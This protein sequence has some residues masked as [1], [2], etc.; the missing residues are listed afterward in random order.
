[1]RAAS[2]HD[3]QHA[4]APAEGYFLR[5][6]TGAG[7]R[8]GTGPDSNEK[9]DRENTRC[10]GAQPGGCALHPAGQQAPPACG[11]KQDTRCQDDRIANPGTGD[12]NGP[13]SENIRNTCPS[14]EQA[15]YNHP[16]CECPAFDAIRS[17]IHLEAL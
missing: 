2:G 4:V 16:E 14:R 11:Q 15:Q 7:T 6:S 17:S 9:G 10:Y 13:I 12:Q 8:N 1:M 3:R 5:R